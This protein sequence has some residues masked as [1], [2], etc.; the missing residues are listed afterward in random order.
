VNA[1]MNIQVPRNAGTFLTSL[2]AVSF[3]GGTLLHGVRWLVIC[4]TEVK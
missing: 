3:S 2:G 1:V 4:A